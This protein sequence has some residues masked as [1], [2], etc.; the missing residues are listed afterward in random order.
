MA[1][2]Y[3]LRSARPVM[4]SDTRSG[5]SLWMFQA[6]P[7]YYIWNEVEGDV[8]EVVKPTGLQEIVATITDKGL[9][10]VELNQL[11]EKA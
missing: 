8:F 4:C 3:G 1:A 7:T 6:G 5:D 10:E 2:K 9:S 11:E